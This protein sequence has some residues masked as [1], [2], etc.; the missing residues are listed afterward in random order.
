V[1]TGNYRDLISRRAKQRKAIACAEC[2]REF[3]PRH[4]QRK[5]CYDP[6]C[7]LKRE[8]KRSKKAAER[9]R[10]KKEEDRAEGAKRKP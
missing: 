10:R 1:K 3:V 9:A 5:Y 8:R 4:G 7:E 2:G 6:A